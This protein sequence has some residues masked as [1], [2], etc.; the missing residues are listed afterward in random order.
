M[1]ST[2]SLWFLTSA[3]YLIKLLIIWMKNAWTFIWFLAH[4][5]W[6]KSN[7]YEVRNFSMYHFIIWMCEMRSEIL[8]PSCSYRNCVLQ[9][10]LL[11]SSFEDYVGQITFINFEN[12][13]Q[14]SSD[15]IRFYVSK[16]LKAV[17]VSSFD[18]HIFIF[19][20]WASHML[21]VYIMFTENF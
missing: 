16:E 13:Y 2:M 19:L 14:T 1:C 10:F 20:H 12:F 4:L 7:S 9:S 17:A 18:M 8:K 21:S 5:N 3:K 6:I 11:P 15:I